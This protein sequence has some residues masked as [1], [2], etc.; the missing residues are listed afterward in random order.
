MK[1]LIITVTTAIICL[2]I[3]IF[4]G[5]SLTNNVADVETNKD[6]IVGLDDAYPPIGFRDDQ[7]NIVG[8]DIDL[9]KSA[10]ERLGYTPTFKSVDWEGVILTLQNK[11]I[12]VVWN[13]MTITDS[14]KEQIAFSNPYIF[15]NDIF[16]IK[17]SDNI[18]SSMDLNGQTIGVQAGSSQEET[19]LASDLADSVKI[20]SYSSNDEA[21]LDLKAGRISALLADGYTGRYYLTSL[22]KADNIFSSIDAGFEKSYAGVGIRKEDTDLVSQINQALAELIKDGTASQISEKWFGEDIIVK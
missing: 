14:R 6:I 7:G 4:I 20:N 17:N 9:A 1:N 22:S 13:G 16:I 11:E 2:L 12:D 21:F 19:L 5:K 8:F 10:F 18:K 15:S 3:G